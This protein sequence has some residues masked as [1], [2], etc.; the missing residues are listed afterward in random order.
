MGRRLLSRSSIHYLEHVQVCED[1]T[2]DICMFLDSIIMYLY[3]YVSRFSYYVS[4]PQS[5]PVEYA[6]AHVFFPLQ[7]HGVHRQCG[8]VAQ[9]VCLDGLDTDIHSRISLAHQRC[10]DSYLDPSGRI[11]TVIV[12]VFDRLHCYICDYWRGFLSCDAASV[13]RLQARL[14]LCQST[15]PKPTPPQPSKPQQQH[16][17]GARYL[18][19]NAQRVCWETT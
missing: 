14:M 17:R 18:S 19:T 9:V 10:L 3:F 16:T 13:L 1:M 7:H 4:V 2:L 8:A 11:T 15:P 12:V 6:T 5:R